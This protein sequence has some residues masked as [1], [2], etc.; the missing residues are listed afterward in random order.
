MEQLKVQD[1]SADEGEKM[2][3]DT[4]EYAMK[5]SRGEPEEERGWLS[6]IGDENGEK[7]VD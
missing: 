6:S 5:P 2:S 7:N 4:R 3:D 1:T